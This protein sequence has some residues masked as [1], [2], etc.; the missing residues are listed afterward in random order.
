MAAM[1]RTTTRPIKIISRRTGS[2]SLSV[3]ILCSV[4]AVA[5]G[6]AVRLQRSLEGARQVLDLAGRPLAL[7]LLR[8]QL[9][10]GGSNL[11]H[12][13]RNLVG[14]LALLLGGAQALVEHVGG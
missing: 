12:R 5:H 14:G 3:D 4:S 7:L 11:G 9:L 1:K 10:G 8:G 6:H 13:R 2:S